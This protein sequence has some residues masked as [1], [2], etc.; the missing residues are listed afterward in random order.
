M[1]RLLCVVCAISLLFTLLFAGGCAGEQ[2][3]APLVPEHP[4]D[5]E[6][7]GKPAGPQSPNDPPSNPGDARAKRSSRGG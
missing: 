7:P 2:P 3:D 1:R 5:P 4:L 6:G